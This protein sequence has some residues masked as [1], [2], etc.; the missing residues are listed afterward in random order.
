MPRISAIRDIQYWATEPRRDW[1]WE[2]EGRVNVRKNRH[3]LLFDYQ[4]INGPPE[5]W[6][7]FERVSRG[8][9]INDKT[10]EV[11]A[12]PYDK[13]WNWHE[14][15]DP[16]QQAIM[17]ATEKMD[18]YMGTL[19]RVGREYR[20]A[21]RHQFHSP[22]AETA[23]AMLNS[24]R[25]DLRPIPDEATLIFEVIYPGTPIVVDYGDYSGLFLLDVRN[26]FTGEYW[27]PNRVSRLAGQCRFDRPKR[28]FFGSVDIITANCKYLSNNEE[29][30]VAVMQDGTR[31]KFKSPA[32]VYAHQWMMHM[33]PRNIVRVMQENRVTEV[34]SQ[35]T[36]PLL[37]K[38]DLLCNEIRHMYHELEYQI[39]QAAIE[40][41]HSGMDRKEIAHWLT[42]QYPKEK[43]V[44]SGVFATLD[45]KSPNKTIWGEILRQLK[46]QADT[47]I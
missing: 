40:A 4:N 15:T 38:F 25:Y 28:Y 22:H 21:T 39:N 34:R 18:G 1:D 26:R 17:Y 9:I 33:T 37:L 23:T 27:H 13:F 16:P 29:G 35:L 6:N 20:I 32:Y 46:E 12:R 19:Y 5:S 45:G 3:L 2:Q 24:D 11:V 31:V 30:Y 43:A 14:Y 36:T 41:A 42:E 8:L 47:A 7:F 44:R 10:G